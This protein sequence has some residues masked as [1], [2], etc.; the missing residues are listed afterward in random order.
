[1]CGV[2]D[3]PGVKCVIADIVCKQG[4]HM[5][6]IY[7]IIYYIVCCCCTRECSPIYHIYSTVYIICHLPK[8]STLIFFTHIYM[9]TQR[10]WLGS[11]VNMLS[12][13]CW[14]IDIDTDMSSFRVIDAVSPSDRMCRP[15]IFCLHLS[16]TSA[17]FPSI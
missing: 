5:H 2:Q 11:R 14:L 9:T 15:P 13:T 10:G 3:M 4:I 1:M 7:I 8:G 12:T 6:Y 16:H 17:S